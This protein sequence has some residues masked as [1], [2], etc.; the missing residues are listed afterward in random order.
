MTRPKNSV[1]DRFLAANV[2]LENAAADTEVQTMLAEFGYNVDKIS[3]GKA[4]YETAQTLHN[5]QKAEYGEQFTATDAQQTL[6]DK[7]DAA[8]MQFVKL[9]RIALRNDRGAYVKLKLEGKRKKTLSGWL[10]QANI[11]YANILNDPAVIEKLSA[12]GIVQTKLEAGRQLLKEVEAANAAQKKETGEAQQATIVRD[13]AMDKLDEWMS[14]FKVV[15]RIALE[16]KSQFLEKLGIV[17][18]S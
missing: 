8:Y 2:A 18:P 16:P 12:F 6:L 13:E 10:H 15:A 4:L 7:A 11:F 5:K 1:E 14:D 9:A 3:E 17:E